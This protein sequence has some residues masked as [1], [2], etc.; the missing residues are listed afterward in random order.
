MEALHPKHE[1]SSFVMVKSGGQRPFSPENRRL[2]SLD[3]SFLYLPV[4][5]TRTPDHEKKR[6]ELS[7]ATIEARGPGRCD[8][9]LIEPC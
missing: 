2:V 6:R 5:L 4:V 9:Y 3:G 7:G 1:P 8:S